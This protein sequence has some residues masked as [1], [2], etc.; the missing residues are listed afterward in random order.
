MRGR[1]SF[2]DDRKQKKIC[3]KIGFV[4]LL[5]LTS[6]AEPPRKDVTTETSTVDV[7]LCLPFLSVSGGWLAL[8]KLI[9]VRSLFLPSPLHIV[10]IAVV[11]AIR[12]D[13]FSFLL[14]YYFFL[15][16]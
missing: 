12:V 11:N 13:A 10:V 9:V 14:R 7:S 6:T 4:C 1:S 2:F 15:D 8:V 3:E 16:G 5:S